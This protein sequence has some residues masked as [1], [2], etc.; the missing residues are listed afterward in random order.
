[1]KRMLP[2]LLVFL[3]APL[4][5]G[6]SAYAADG[7][8]QVAT[9]TRYPTTVITDYVLGCMLS[10]GVSSETLQK[11]SCS[12]DFV[13]ASI[14]YAE[15]ERVQTLLSLQQMPG[16]G[17]AAVYKSSTWAKEAITHLREVQAESTL[18]C[19]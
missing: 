5:V 13:A 3:A 12:F 17:R 1:M 8:D 19:F 4:S 15:Y 6:G 2:A 7:D 10:N 9:E 16:A 18:R 14:P 11:C